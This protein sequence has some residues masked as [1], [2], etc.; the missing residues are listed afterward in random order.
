MF[1]ITYRNIVFELLN[2]ID[3]EVDCLLDFCSVE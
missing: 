2:V 3:I 1:C